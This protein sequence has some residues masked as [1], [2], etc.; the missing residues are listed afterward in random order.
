METPCSKW[1]SSYSTV[2]YSGKCGSWTLQM[3]V[4]V[5]CTTWWAAAS[6]STSSVIAAQHASNSDKGERSYNSS[7]SLTQ[8]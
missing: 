4:F 1:L 2:Q 5:T 6:S 8:M 3:A 7:D